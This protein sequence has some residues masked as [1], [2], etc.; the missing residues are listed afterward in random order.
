MNSKVKEVV[1]WLLT[2]F[3]YIGIALLIRLFVFNIT[4][5][6]GLSMYPT[7]NNK[8]KL[9]T[10]KVTLYFDDPEVGDIVVLKAPDGSGD[11]YIKRVIAKAEDEVEIKEG[12]VYVNGNPLEE[13][14]INGD[15]TTPNL[16]GQDK[17]TIPDGHFF[18]MGDNRQASND[19]R[20][21]GPIAKEEIIG[22]SEYRL[23]PFEKMGKI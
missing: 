13:D 8:D 19:S 10:Q 15:E 5:V 23:L 12:K 20:S 18:V 4:A 14:Y 9:F 21:F 16:I 1:S 22:I 3:F 6:S 17:W 7:L 11:N 2:L